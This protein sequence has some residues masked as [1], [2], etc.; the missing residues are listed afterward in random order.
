MDRS[1]VS[2]ARGPRRRG[3]RHA[4]PDLHGL[5]S[6]PPRVCVAP[7]RTAGDRQRRLLAVLQ[8]EGPSKLR[9]CSVIH[10]CAA[11]KAA[12]ALGIPA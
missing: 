11:R 10:S 3:K 8:A 5:A 12:M 6:R 4:R 1:N 9:P 7:V 2:A